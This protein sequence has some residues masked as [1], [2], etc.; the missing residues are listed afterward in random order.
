MRVSP[1][2]WR[3]GFGQQILAALEQQA[4]DY[5]YHKLRLDTTTRQD[6]AQ[7]LYIKNGYV[8]VERERWH[9]FILIYME[10]QLV[11]IDDTKKLEEQ[12]LNNYHYDSMTIEPSMAEFNM[13]DALMLER[14]LS[15]RTRLDHA[16]AQQ[17][18]LG[19]DPIH[20]V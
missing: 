14:T 5:G 15:M 6:A 20:Q 19:F 9:E 13:D 1:D 16:S 12:L 17:P 8:E 2:Y 4:R 18:P 11:D 7:K 3:Q 10:K